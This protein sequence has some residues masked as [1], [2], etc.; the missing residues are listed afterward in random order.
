MLG[1]FIR[2]LRRLRAAVG[3]IEARGNRRSA[4]VFLYLPSTL[5]QRG[6]AKLARKAHHLA[7]FRAIDRR[8]FRAFSR[9]HPPGQRRFY[10]I[11]MPGTLHFVVPCLALLPTHLDVVLIA[12]GAAA[13]E[14]SYLARRFSSYPMVTLAT[15][16]GASVA[17]GDVIT[18]LL[19]SSERPFGILD[20]DCYVFD[21]S[22]FEELVLDDR[23]CIA[24]VYGDV[25]TRV[26]IAY[27]Q[28]YLLYLDPQALRPIMR[29]YGVDAGSYRTLPRSTRTALQSIGIRDGVYLKDYHDYY[30]TLHVLIALA[31]AENWRLRFVQA[32]TESSMAHVGSTSSGLAHTKELFHSYVQLKFLELLDDSEISRRYRS[33]THPFRHAQ[34]VEAH[35]PRTPAMFARL[36]STDALIERLRTRMADCATGTPAP[37]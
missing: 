14:R 29:R 11:V 2:N 10:V 25:A 37:K 6:Y 33:R 24:A 5:A 7:A 31:L 13:W 22:V 9:R 18:L 3:R 19:M 1:A 26:A 27:P 20:H 8:T 21:A 16:P 4:A 12:N 17:H 32:I 36:R 34:D 35:C 15:L 28:T 30:D 23:E